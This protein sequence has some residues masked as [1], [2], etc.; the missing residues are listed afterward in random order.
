MGEAMGEV[1]PLILT[2][3][4]DTPK[5]KKVGVQQ[6]RFKPTFLISCSP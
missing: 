6:Y 4:N 5:R 3:P 1:K 2:I